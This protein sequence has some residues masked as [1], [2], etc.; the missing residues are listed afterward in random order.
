MKIDTKLIENYETLSPE[1]KI[2]ALE[3]LELPDPDYSGHVEKKLYDKVASDLAAAKKQLGDKSAD[4]QALQ[5]LKG[6]YDELMKQSTITQFEKEFLGLGYEAKLAADTA[7][8]MAEGDMQTVFKNQAAFKVEIEK[9]AK[10]TEIKKTPYP[11][12]GGKPKGDEDTELATALGKQAAEVS[13]SSSEVL[14]KYL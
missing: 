9:Q 3:A 14:G 10:S 5:D 8:A 11:P 1:D 4:S 7:K 2:K 6:K 12:T 13:K